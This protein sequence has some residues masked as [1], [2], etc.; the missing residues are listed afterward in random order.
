MT[1]RKSGVASKQLASARRK[2]HQREVLRNRIIFGIIC[3]MLLALIIFSIVK[4]ISLFT[5]SFDESDVSKLT[6]NTDGTIIY[7]EITEFDEEIYS[8]KDFKNYIKPLIES[9]NETMGSESI[10]IDKIKFKND[11]AYVRT[12]YDSADT[13][14]SFTSYPLFVGQIDEAMEA[15]YDFASIFVKV[16]N[17]IVGETV[18]F[19]NPTF[20]D[21]LNVAIIKENTLVSVP[22]TI[23]YISNHSTNLVEDTTNE[24]AISQKDGN[25]DATETVY[26]IYKADEEK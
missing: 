24:V 11:T 1:E 9:Y 6:I 3:A 8:E 20:F 19:S 25:N 23:E 15:G 18:E 14:T 12:K 2:R 22:G 4:I 17:G 10:V 26:I 7:E 16:D 21:D 13:Y 5:N